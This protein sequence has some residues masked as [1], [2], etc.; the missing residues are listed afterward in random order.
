MNTEAQLK[1]QLNFKTIELKRAQRDID[2]YRL[3]AGAYI[4][5]KRAETKVRTLTQEIKQINSK[6]EKLSKAQE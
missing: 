1:A 3:S 2:T 5:L 6:I 4:M